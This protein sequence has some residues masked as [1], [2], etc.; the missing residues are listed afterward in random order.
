MSQKPKLRKGAQL[1]C[2]LNKEEFE[3]QTCVQQ[4][5]QASGHFGASYQQYRSREIVPQEPATAAI[6][7]AHA[8][9]CSFGICHF[10]TYPT[11]F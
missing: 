5:K 11:P 9:Q 10:S 8:L 3:R 4:K 1:I 2:A 6:A 7:A